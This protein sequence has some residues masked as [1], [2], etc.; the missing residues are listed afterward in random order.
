[1]LRCDLKNTVHAMKLIQKKDF[2]LMFLY[3]LSLDNLGHHQGFCSKEY[4]SHLYTIDLLIGKILESLDSAGILAE[5]TVMLVSD[6]GA[7]PGTNR[8]GELNDAN[9]FAP[10][11]VMGPGIKPN[12]RI[13]ANVHLTDVAP[14]IAA[15]LELE[16]HPDWRGKVI[17]EIFHA[18]FKQH[19]FAI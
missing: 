17:S 3:F 4:N 8:H 18:P 6:H 13:T 7:T 1:M 10:L 12:H 19:K 2:D 5:T 15:V 14:T 11:I 16:P 9:L